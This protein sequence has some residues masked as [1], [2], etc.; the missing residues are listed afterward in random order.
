MRPTT[1]PADSPRTTPRAV[2]SKVLY[3]RERH[4]FG[5]G[6]TANY[7]KRF[8][9]LTVARSTVHCILSRYGVNRPP[10]NQK[11]HRTGPPGKETPRQR[12]TDV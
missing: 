12:V 11:R 3:L 8:H 9:H 7:L 5:P 1:R 2:I 10:A 4:S 6:R